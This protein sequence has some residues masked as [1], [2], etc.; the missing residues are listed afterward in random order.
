MKLSS[1][2]RLFQRGAGTDRI[3]KIF[4]LSASAPYSNIL[5]SNSL[6]RHSKLPGQKD[7]MNV[8]S[9]LC[10]VRDIPCIHNWYKECLKSIQH[11]LFIAVKYTF[12]KYNLYYIQS[13]H[14]LDYWCSTLQ[15]TYVVVC[16]VSIMHRLWVSL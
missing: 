10:L 16:L 3:F 5:S 2:V 15:A 9:I 7:A 12:I 11:R 8:W 1:I 14:S 6:V 4:K 13:L